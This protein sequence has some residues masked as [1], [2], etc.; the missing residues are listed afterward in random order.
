MVALLGLLGMLAGEMLAGHLRGRL[1]AE[2]AAADCL[3]SKS[4]AVPSEAARDAETP[5]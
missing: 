4:F 2:A 1:T 3:H 5:S